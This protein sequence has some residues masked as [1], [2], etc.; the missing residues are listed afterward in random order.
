MLIEGWDHPP[1]SCVVILR[2][3]SFFAT[4]AQMIGRGMRPAPGKKD[5][6]V[7]DFGISTLVHSMQNDGLQQKPNLAGIM[8]QTETDGDGGGPIIDEDEDSNSSDVDIVSSNG[9]AEPSPAISDNFGMSAI[10]LLD[11]V[12][13]DHTASSAA[14]EKPANDTATNNSNSCRGHKNGYDEDM[15][16]RHLQSSYALWRWVPCRQQRPLIPNSVMAMNSWMGSNVAVI[17]AL[18]QYYVIGG[19]SVTR[20]PTETKVWQIRYVGADYRK[21]CQEAHTWL[22]LVGLL[23]AVD[24]QPY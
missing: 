16:M 8:E 15:I 22:Q 4:M 19:S 13:H 24:Y 12:F 18:Q 23:F 1:T 5:C 17:Y 2:P 10:D 11:C 20:E 14:D 21:A 3:L 7:L 6:V 9:L